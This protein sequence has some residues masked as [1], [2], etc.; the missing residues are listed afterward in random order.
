MGILLYYTPKPHS[1]Y[2]RGT[3]GFGV[4]GWAGRDQDW[5][6]R[7]VRNLKVIRLVPSSQRKH[8]NPTSS[9]RC[10]CIMIPWQGVFNNNNYHN[11]FWGMFLDGAG[12]VGPASKNPRDKDLT[13]ISRLQ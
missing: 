5:H 7:T 13:G 12:I 3:V 11:R 10:Y 6:S 4:S 8:T 1:I 9:A 2:L